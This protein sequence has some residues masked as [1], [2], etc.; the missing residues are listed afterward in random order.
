MHKIETFL[1]VKKYG[2]LV[3]FIYD[4]ETETGNRLV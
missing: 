4:Y 2:K 3:I 1:S